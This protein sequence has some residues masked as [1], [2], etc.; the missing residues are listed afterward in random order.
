MEAAR[1]GEAGKGFAVVATEVKDLAQETAKATEDITRRIQ[2]IQGDTD[3][4]VAA[5][6]RIDEVVSQISDYQTT[7]AS[8]VEEQTATTSEMSRGVTEAAQGTG[9]IADAVVTVS[10]VSTE[11][12]QDALQARTA[13]DGG[14]GDRGAVPAGVAVPG[15]TMRPSDARGAAPAS[16][17]RPCGVLLPQ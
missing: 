10:T 9:S 15:L 2:A 8:A 6:A 14:R 16:R 12:E 13:A 7:I 3:R 1:A 4:A 17:D 11:T 5:I